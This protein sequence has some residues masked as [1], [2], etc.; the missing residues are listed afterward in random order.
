MKGRE[1]DEM[2]KEM[3]EKQNRPIKVQITS[4]PHRKGEEKKQKG[5]TSCATRPTP[6][7]AIYHDFV[8]CWFGED[9]D[10]G[11]DD[12]VDDYFDV[13]LKEW[14]SRLVKIFDDDIVYIDVDI[15]VY[16]YVDVDVDVD[17][18]DDVD[19]DNLVASQRREDRRVGVS[20]NRRV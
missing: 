6:K 4:R 19:K 15:D 14:P 11:G 20:R 10:G 9:D 12:D 1:V 17:K 5:G 8:I 3:R 2:Q 18:D 13:L 7:A 16:V